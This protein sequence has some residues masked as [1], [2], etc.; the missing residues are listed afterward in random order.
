MTVT[1]YPVNKSSE[2]HSKFFHKVHMYKKLNWKKFGES[3]FNNLLNFFNYFFY[4]H[5]LVFSQNTA[6]ITCVNILYYFAVQW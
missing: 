6:N 2:L 1:C 5:V 4:M 3:I